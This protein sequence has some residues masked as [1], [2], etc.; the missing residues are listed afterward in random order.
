M[1]QKEQNIDVHFVSFLHIVIWNPSS[2]KARTYLFY[3]VNVM[4]ADV[5]ATQGAT[6]SATIIFTLLNQ[7]HSV[8]AR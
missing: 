7:I 6:A 4:C 2:S 3:I 5:L 8:P 1:F